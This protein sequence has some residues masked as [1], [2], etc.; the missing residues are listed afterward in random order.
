[1]PKL[2]KKAITRFYVI[3]YI[4]MFKN[5]K[6]QDM[7]EISTELLQFIAPNVKPIANRGLNKEGFEIKPIENHTNEI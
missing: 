7:N 4:F 3:Y 5:K 6:S 2:T 1:M